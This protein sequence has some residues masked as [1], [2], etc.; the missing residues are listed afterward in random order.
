MESCR[1]EL[2]SPTRKRGRHL[3]SFSALVA[4]GLYL[5][6]AAAP[7]AAASGDIFVSE[8]DGF[9]GSG[10]VIRVNPTTG[11]RATVSANASPVGGPSFVGPLRDRVCRQRR[12]LCGRSQAFGGTGG[13]IRV[14]PTTGARPHTRLGELVATGRA[15]LRG[16]LRDRDHRRRR[17][18]GGRLRGLRRHRRR[19]SRQ[20]DHRSTYDRLVE[21]L[22][23]GRPELRR[24]IRD[25]ACCQRR[26]PGG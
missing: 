4:V 6:I 5:L 13:V 2:S 18:P 19:D 10:G 7:A 25:R 1:L 26:H 20:P 24:P 9:G 22:A 3:F 15:E 21:L 14:N 17:H 8:A 11:A 23:A 12:H 16:P